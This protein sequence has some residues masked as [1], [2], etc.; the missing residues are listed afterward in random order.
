MASTITRA[1]LLRGDLSGARAPIRPPWSKGESHFTEHCSRCGECLKACPETILQPGAGG[2]PAVDF[3][4]GMCTFCGD[5]ASACP[6]PALTLNGDPGRAPWKLRATPLEEACLA[7]KGVVCRA[8]GEQCEL[9]A[10][11]FRPRPGGMA[12]V[13]VDESACNGCGACVRPCPTGA[14]VVRQ[15]AGGRHEEREERCSA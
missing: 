4:I 13:M 15:P 14:V 2:F 7:R 11:R 5:C 1:Q 9:G 6:E 3:N 8:C 12:D 10:I